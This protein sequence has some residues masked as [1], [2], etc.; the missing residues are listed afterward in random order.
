MTQDT[1]SANPLTSTDDIPTQPCADIVALKLL[2]EKREA[3]KQ[4]Q[5]QIQNLQA[6][7]EGLQNTA[8]R[9]MPLDTAVIVCPGLMAIM[10]DPEDRHPINF[11]P[12]EGQ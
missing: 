7:C 1:T 12:V 8:A 4:F 10:F 3:I 11:Y 2:W 9:T 6:E 5:L